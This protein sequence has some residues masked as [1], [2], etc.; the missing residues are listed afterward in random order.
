MGIPG[1]IGSVR[2]FAELARGAATSVLKGHDEAS[3]RTVVV[4]VLRSEWADDVDLVQRFKAEADALAAVNSD[5]V[6]RILEHGDSESGPYIITEFVEGRTLEALVA[7]RTVPAILGAWII[8]EAVVGLCALHDAGLIHRDFKSSNILVGDDGG[9]KL[10][11]LGLV[12]SAANPTVTAAGTPGYIAPEVLA[13]NAATRTSDLFSVGITLLEAATGQKPRQVRPGQQSLAMHFGDLLASADA[14]LASL[15][16]Q[17]VAS[18]PALRPAN[19]DDVLNRLDAILN[20]YRPKINRDTLSRWISGERMT[21]PRR[22]IDQDTTSD[23]GNLVASISASVNDRRKSVLF[24][25]RGW[26]IAALLITWALVVFLVRRQQSADSPVTSAASDSAASVEDGASPVDTL[27]REA[28]ASTDGTTASTAGTTASFDGTAKS[29]SP[30]PLEPANDEISEDPGIPAAAI[31]SDEGEQTAPPEDGGE[32]AGLIDSEAN[33]KSAESESPA[34]RATGYAVVAA[35]PWA[36][37]EIDGSGAGTTPLREAITL[38]SGAHRVLFS[39]PMFPDLSRQIVIAPGDTT[40]VTVSMWSTV[41]RVN[42]SVTPW[43]EVLVDDVVR[44]TIPLNA[45]LIIRPGMRKLTL[46]H[47]ELGT[48]DDLINFKADTTYNLSFNLYD[49]LD[50]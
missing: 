42:L 35:A 23:S 9:V 2:P 38:D 16:Q 41:A 48:W 37:V 22:M 1:R 15:H 50:R 10:V 6:V 45:P 44:D 29:G 46:R 32:V 30:E 24:R 25:I 39:N 21:L 31:A 49:L 7:E 34:R 12:D 36:V 5:H 14:D 13:G 18:D 27:E 8:R 43:A 19:C 4:K 40:Y 47:P 17:L 28:A 26:H 3:D 11:D 33:D 20:G